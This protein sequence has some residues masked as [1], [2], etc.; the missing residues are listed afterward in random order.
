[1][2]DKVQEP[3]AHQVR[4]LLEELLPEERQLLNAVIAAEREKLYMERPRGI[5]EEIWRAITET[6]K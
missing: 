2:S 1:M 5:H 6:I 3:I 4:R